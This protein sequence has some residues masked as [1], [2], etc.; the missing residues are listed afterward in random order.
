MFSISLH[1]NINLVNSFKD[2][3]GDA[4]ARGEF[5]TLC[6]IR[7]ELLERQG[8]SARHDLSFHHSIPI[9]LRYIQLPTALVSPTL[10]VIYAQ[11]FW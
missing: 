7:L 10:S 1:F 4:N 11:A 3:S 6:H 8:A 2:A 9:H 5:H